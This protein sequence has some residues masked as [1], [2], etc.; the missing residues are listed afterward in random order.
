MLDIILVDSV[1][2]CKTIVVV[3]LCDLKIA[4]PH[5]QPLQHCSVVYVLKQLTQ[6]NISIDIRRD[7]LG[8]QRAYSYPKTHTGHLRYNIILLAV[9]CIKPLWRDPFEIHLISSLP[10]FVL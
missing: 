1:V 4:P 2:L 5:I 9:R 8:G 7:I 3:S 6:L 10:F